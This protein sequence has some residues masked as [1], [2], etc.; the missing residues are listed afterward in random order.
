M[1]HTFEF[2]ATET[3]ASLTMSS[4]TPFELEE[5]TLD[6]WREAARKNIGAKLKTEFLLDPF[7]I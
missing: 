2:E 6:V 1:D 7:Y 4:A 5:M 3:T